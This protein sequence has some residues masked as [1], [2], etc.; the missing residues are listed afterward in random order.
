MY[1]EI[2]PDWI[3][4]K[5]DAMRFVGYRVT[6][7]DLLVKKGELPPGIPLSDSSRAK[8]WL[9]RHRLAFR[10]KQMAKVNTPAP[11]AMV[12]RARLAREGKRDESKKETRAE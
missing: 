3:Y 5:R 4:R 1:G 6:Q 7:F 8:G 10:E 11:R 12:E 2:E 9:G